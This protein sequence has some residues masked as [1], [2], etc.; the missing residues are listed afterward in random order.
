[1]DVGHTVGKAV[2][3]NSTVEM[4]APAFPVSKAYG[5]V[6]QGVISTALAGGAIHGYCVER[7]DS[8]GI[9]DAFSQYH[10]HQQEG[11][12]FGDIVAGRQHRLPVTY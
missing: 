10:Y 4:L 3:G 11:L 1:L 5:T 8:D 12:A 9:P 2:T 7:P 6:S